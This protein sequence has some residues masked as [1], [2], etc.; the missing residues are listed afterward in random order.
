LGGK[1]VRG[2]KRGN[3]KAK[4]EKVKVKWKIFYKR[5][6]KRPKLNK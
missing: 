3:L 4:K 6:E 1:Y 2:E 5:T